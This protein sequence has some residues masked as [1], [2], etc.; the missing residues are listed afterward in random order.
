MELITE[1][2]TTDQVILSENSLAVVEFYLPH[3]RACNSFSA[4]YQELAETNPDVQFYKMD[5]T[6]K[7][8]IDQN[9]SELWHISAVPTLLIFDK[10]ISPDSELARIRGKKSKEIIQTLVDSYKDDS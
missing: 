8:F 2:N 6:K 4:V 10:E 3:C 7:G 5:V 9:P 1:L